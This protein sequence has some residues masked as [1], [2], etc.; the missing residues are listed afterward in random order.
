MEDASW[1]ECAEAILGYR[2]F[3]IIVPPS[4]YQAAKQVFTSLGEKVGDVSLVDTPSLMRDSQKWSPPETNM[5]AYKVGSENHAARQY[6]NYLLNRIVCCEEASELE[7]F[8]RSVTRGLLRHQGYRLQ[9]MRKPALCI[10]IDAR[11]QRIAYLEAQLKENGK[12]QLEL[13]QQFKQLKALFPS[14]Q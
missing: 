5:L 2:R 8:S 6:V 3:D 1:Q 12:R 7:D 9:R 13:G 10:G 11:R 14:Q 4:H